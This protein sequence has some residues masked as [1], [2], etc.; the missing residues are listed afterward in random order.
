MGLG[1]TVGLL[2]DMLQEDPDGAEMI[3][4]DLDWVNVALA[5]NGLPHHNEPR[6]C[7]VWSG[8]GYGY[9]GLHALRE[10]AAL[11]WMGQDIPRDTLLNGEQKDAG[12]THFDACVPLMDEPENPGFLA[13]LLGR[14]PGARKVLPFLHLSVHGDAE[15]HYVPQDFAIPVMPK[16]ASDDAAHLWPVGSA[17]QLEAEMEALAEALQMP[18]T[19]S[20]EDKALIAAMDDPAQGVEAPLWQV[21][22]I[23]AQS[24]ALLR[25]ACRQSRMTGAAIV[26]C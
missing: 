16:T 2:A 21:Q 13:R 25:D 19:M 9:R 23:A 14:K 11:V 24:C 6:D 26:F 18:A 15:G 1:I 12:N 4:A 10:V 5:D 22:P 17:V 7:A 8:E 3:A 20:C